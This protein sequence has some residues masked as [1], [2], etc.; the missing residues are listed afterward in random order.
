MGKLGMA[1]EGLS[2]DRATKPPGSRAE[3]EQELEGP[4]R[5]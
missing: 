4:V 3:S 2:V 5:C 1:E